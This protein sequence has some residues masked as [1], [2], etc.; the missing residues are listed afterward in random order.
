MASSTGRTLR[1]AAINTSFRVRGSVF[2]PP[3]SPTEDRAAADGDESGSGSSSPSSGLPRNAPRRSMMLGRMAADKF[4]AQTAGRFRRMSMMPTSFGG[5]PKPDAED[6]GDPWGA[7]GP[8]A[9]AHSDGGYSDDGCAPNLARCP[10]S[11]QVGG[12]SG[13][14]CLLGAE[15]WKGPSR[16][17][18]KWHDV[19]CTHRRQR[20][21]LRSS[22][23]PTAASAFTPAP[24]PSLE[25]VQYSTSSTR[26]GG[27]LR[28]LWSSA[29]TW[30]APLFLCGSK[31]P[32]SRCAAVLGL[33]YL[34]CLAHVLAQLRVWEGMQALKLP[35]LSYSA[36]CTLK[37][38]AGWAWNW[39][40]AVIP[41]SNFATRF[42]ADSA[43]GLFC[44]IGPCQELLLGCVG[45]D[46]P[47]MAPCGKFFDSELASAAHVAESRE[48][49]SKLAASQQRPRGKAPRPS[50]FVGILRNVE[51]TLKV[52]LPGGGGSPADSPRAN[53]ALSMRS[54]THLLPIFGNNIPKPTDVVATVHAQHAGSPL[55]RIASPMSR[56]SPAPPPRASPAARP[57][58][59]AAS[60]SRT[61]QPPSGLLTSATTPPSLLL[62]STAASPAPRSNG[63]RESIMRSPS[64]IRRAYGRASVRETGPTDSVAGVQDVMKDNIARLQVRTERLQTLESKTEDMVSDAEGFAAMAKKVES[65]A[66]SW[67]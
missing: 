67:W 7:G 2:S 5:S 8:V 64:E 23:S 39:D 27:R 57:A 41:C 18:Q 50:M 21:R 6:G 36:T 29:Q 30:T 56:S 52:Q 66:K 45:S 14:V 44:L 60:G 58:P 17:V 53:A 55:A 38:F 62:G 4:K 12:T 35:E 34:S 24:L 20:Q 49:S 63:R 65:N 37:E 61:A 47:E 51:T 59:Q 13:H 9:E 32:A 54:G 11:P 25:T 22:S 10:D 1:G 33:S 19:S 40:R 28:V 15:T 42:A 3:G 48:D 16:K 43:S 46:P 26:L 31:A